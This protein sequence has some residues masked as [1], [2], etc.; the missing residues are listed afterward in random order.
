MIIH[1]N[2]WPGVG[3]KTI[4]Q[5]VASRLG[6]RFVHNHL[7]HDVAIACHGLTDPARWT[8]YEQL[9]RAAY[10][11]LRARP[12]DEVF[13]MTNALCT[14]SDRER[15]AWNHVVDLA[16]DRKVPLIPIVLEAAFAENARRLQ[17]SQ[18]T[19]RKMT[20]P[21]LLQEF[22][23]ADT[24]Q[25]PDMTELLVLDVTRL[26]PDEAAETI[27]QHISALTAEGKLRTATPT[28]SRLR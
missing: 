1:L 20:D 12:R 3:K 24:I 10:A 28:A 4:G 18:R 22:M 11:A 2:G 23:A 7:L 16:V 21:R 27:L 5:I 13:V 25:K 26:L 19:G 6:A 15:G 8:L 17:D 9:R 14:N